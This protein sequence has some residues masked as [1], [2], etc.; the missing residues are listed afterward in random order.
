MAVS[1]SFHIF[2]C[3][4]FL[5]SVNWY[6]TMQIGHCHFGRGYMTYIHLGEKNTVPLGGKWR[7]TDWYAP[8]LWTTWF[9]TFS[10]S[11]LVSVNGKYTLLLRDVTTKYIIYYSFINLKFN[12]FR[13]HQMNQILFNYMTSLTSCFG[14]GVRDSYFWMYLR[15]I[16]FF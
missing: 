1:L 14:Y 11:F 10:M 2:L 7:P 3:F 16:A 9:S 8:L 13:L 5:Q 4:L 15:V 12:I 6:K